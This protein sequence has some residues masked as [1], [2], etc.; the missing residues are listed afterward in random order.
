MWTSNVSSRRSRHL[1]GAAALA[2]LIAASGFAGVPAIAQTPATAPSQGFGDL[3]E[4]VMPAVVSVDARLGRNAPAAGESE[5]GESPFALPEIPPDSPFRQFFDQFPRSP[6]PSPQG[7]G[8]SQG[9]GFII[10]ADGYVVT[11][12]H[13]VQGAEELTVR[14]NTDE[15]Y[16]A[17]VVGTDPKTDL[18]L[19]KIESG[20]PFAFVTFAKKEPRVGDWVIAVGN[21]FGLGGTVTTGIISARG[22]NIGSGPYDDFLQIDAPINKGNSGGP[23]FNLEGEV[24][25]INTAIFSPSGGSVGIGFAIPA[26]EAVHVIDDLREMGAVTRG[27]LGVQIQPITDDIAE[28]VGLK[29]DDGA[30]VADVTPNSPALKA[31][32]RTGDAIVKLNGAAVKDPSDLSKR[33]ARLEPGQQATLTVMREGAETEVAFTVGKMP[34][35]KELVAALDKG[36]QPAKP[37]PTRLGL[38]LEPAPDGR[39]V[40]IAGVAQDSP[41]ATKGL[42]PGDIILQAGGVD[43]DE[44]AALSAAIEEAVRNGQK[45]VLCL[46]RSGDR[47]RFVAIP[48][49]PT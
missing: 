41:A 31:G 13:V 29:G 37:V 10:S 4:K 35:D 16:T 1:I 18:A 5:E 48:T 43:V 22:R 15:E 36:G 9:S 30:L 12:N 27:W 19:L 39:G 32:L 40:L 7:R 24:I 25:G 26:Y 11:N 42:K 6:Q 33:V 49:S 14:T 34:G 23:A 17:K 45:H 28:S 8:V 21:P 38:S 20:K 44:P 47:Q 46:V 3:V 2:A